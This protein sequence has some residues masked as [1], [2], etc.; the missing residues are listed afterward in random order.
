MNGSKSG[1]TNGAPGAQ[2]SLEQMELKKIISENESSAKQ[3]EASLMNELK[4]SGAKFKKDDIVFIAKDKGGQLVWLEN[5]NDTAGL[6]HIVKRHGK[7]FEAK[8]NISK[9]EIK[10]HLKKIF[11]DGDVKY[12]RV[13]YKNGK[14]GMEKLYQYKKKY[15][16]L[17][18]IGTNGFI[19]TCYPIDNETANKL[20]GR[21][22]NGR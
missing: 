6:I 1:L 22:N 8:H 4:M 12:S 5:G 14:A 18:G 9:S 7:D 16:L 13:I 20:Y 21:Y 17:S 19:V 11:T 3:D 2:T 10:I 15:Y